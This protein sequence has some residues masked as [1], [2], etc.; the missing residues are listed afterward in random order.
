MSGVLPAIVARLQDSLGVTVE[1]ARAPDAPNE[2]LLIREYPAAP[3]RDL[4]PNAH[5]AL[6]LHSVQVI[7]RGTSVAAAENLAWRAYRALPARHLSTTSGVIDWITA[8]HTPH[9]VGFDEN[10]RALVVCN[11]TLQRWGDLGRLIAR[12]AAGTI[13]IR[14]NS[15]NVTGGGP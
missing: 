14:G 7:A 8:N 3:P 10:D 4:D 12:V 5:A 9:H 6:E 15:P 1:L 11:F 2:L 13:I